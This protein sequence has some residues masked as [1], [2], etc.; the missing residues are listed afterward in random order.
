MW[1]WVCLFGNTL[2]NG[3]ICMSMKVLFKFNK[4]QVNISLYH[5]DVVSNLLIKNLERPNEYIKTILN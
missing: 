3:L 2:N 4:I 5:N 1:P